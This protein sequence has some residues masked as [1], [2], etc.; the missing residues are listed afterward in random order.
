MSQRI[1]LDTEE[2][3]R[4]AEKMKAIA[5]AIKKSGDVVAAKTSGLKDY[6][7]QLPTKKFA[8][9]TQQ[10]A[11]AVHDQMQADAEH[12]AHIADL[13]EAVDDRLIDGMVPPPPYR[14]PDQDSIHGLPNGTVWDPNT[15]DG[16]VMAPGDNN[17]GPTQNINLEDLLPGFQYK[18]PKHEPYYYSQHLCGEMTL[19]HLAGI[20]DPATGFMI[21]M[22]DPDL[23][24]KLVTDTNLTPQ[25]MMKLCKMLGMTPGELVAF[26]TGTKIDPEAFK[27]ILA[28]GGKVVVLVNYLIPPGT[29]VDPKKGEYA[30][31]WVSVEDMWEDSE[32]TLWVKVYDPYTNQYTAYRW[33]TLEAAMQ[34]PGKYSEGWG[35]YIP[36]YPGSGES[37]PSN[38]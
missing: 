33:D 6:G 8:L 19:F 28:S 24:K 36:V 20:I 31:H 7:G 34:Y 18:P 25:D 3:K 5:A 11:S 13:F 37:D 27:E 32:G 23:Y 4:Q 29:I 15:P 12:M 16:T 17:F 10:T 14:L 2:L 22:T 35:Y 38:G 26:T 9:S 1:R 30:G 21:M